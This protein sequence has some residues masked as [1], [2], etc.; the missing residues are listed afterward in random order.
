M[1]EI[2]AHTVKEIAARYR[3]KPH[4]VLA[5]ISRGD[6]RAVDVSQDPTRGRP[7]WRVTPDA[8]IEFEN[9]RCTKPTVKPTRQR[10]RRTPNCIQYF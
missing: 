2:R 1:S 9:R 4:T 7:R 6:L 3:V 10:N 5:W 8:L